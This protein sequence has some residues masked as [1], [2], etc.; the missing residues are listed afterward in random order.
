M[1]RKF[2][3]ANEEKLISLNKDIADENKNLYVSTVHTSHSFLS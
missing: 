3:V 2:P 1:E